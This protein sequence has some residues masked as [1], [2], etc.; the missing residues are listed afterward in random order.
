MKRKA[1]TFVEL[2]VVLAI[3]GILVCLLLP[4]IRKAREAAAG[5]KPKSQTVAAEANDP[6]ASNAKTAV[7]K[8][9]SPV[10]DYANVL[11]PAEAQQLRSVLLA[12]EKTTSNQIVILTIKSLDG[13]AVQDYAVKVFDTWKLGKKGKDNGVLI[14]H[15]PES[16]DIWITTGYGAN[17]PVPDIICG[18]IYRNE[19]VPRFKEGKFFDGYMAAIEALNKAL[20]GEFIAEQVIVNAPK[21]EPWPDWL[22]VVIVIGI[23]ILIVILISA[24]NDVRNGRFFGESFLGLLSEIAAASGDSSGGGSGTSSGG[25]SGWGGSSGGSSGG[26]GYSG[27]G[28]GTPGSGAGGK[29]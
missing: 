11:K 4:A 22:W 9:E 27:G 13:D 20:K 26:G 8:L 18:R 28:G 6:V 7:P 2:L 14:L 16:R 1:F 24:I 5:N 19:M 10:N 12:Q 3:I 21:V 15:V 25:S 29:Y 23:I 17:G